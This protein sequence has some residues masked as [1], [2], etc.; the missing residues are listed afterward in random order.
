M[1]MRLARWRGAGCA[2][3]LH[4]GCAPAQRLTRIEQQ[5]PDALDLMG[6][7][8]RAGH[9]F[10]TVLQMVGDEMT[11]PLAGEFR[12]AFDEINYGVPM[13]DALHN[14]ATRMPAPTCATS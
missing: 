14:L 9:A 12:T 5:L 4:V 13:K 6:R 3:C 1:L 8:L 11:E 2:A 10:P 7:A